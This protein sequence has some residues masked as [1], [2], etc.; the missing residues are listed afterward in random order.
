MHRAQRVPVTG[1]AARSTPRPQRWRCCPRPR[2][3]TSR[4]TTRTAGRRLPRQRRRRS[5]CQPDRER[6]AR[7][8]PADRARGRDPGREVAAQEQGQGPQDPQGPAL[9][10]GARGQ[11]PERAANRKGSRLGRPVERIRTYNFPQN[12]LTD[13]RINLTLYKLTTWSQDAR[14]GDRA[15]INE[16]QAARLAEA[17]VSTVAAAARVDRGAGR[18]RDR[19]PASA[20]HARAPPGGREPAWRAS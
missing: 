3:S 11:G 9:R 16:D 6:C 17:G 20:G 12:R 8:A 1:P 14:R 2:T 4:S 18:G 19:E 10:A 15:L 7:H 13:H 5:A